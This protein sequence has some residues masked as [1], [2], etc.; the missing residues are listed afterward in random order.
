MA[1]SR[2]QDCGCPDGRRGNVYST[3]PHFPTGHPN[4]GIVCGTGPCQ[5]PGVL[6]LTVEEENEYL[7]GRRI[8]QITG[9]HMASKFSVL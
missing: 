8:F 7:Q 3:T 2:C 6:W 4:S 1:V 9:G 5:N